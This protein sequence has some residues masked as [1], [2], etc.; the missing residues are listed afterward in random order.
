M[1]ITFEG[2]EC[3]FCM[4]DGIEAFLIHRIPRVK[5]DNE[6]GMRY[7]SLEGSGSIMRSGCISR[8]SNMLS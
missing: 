3:W 2:H 4:V 1:M 8:E 5:G 6:L 7:F